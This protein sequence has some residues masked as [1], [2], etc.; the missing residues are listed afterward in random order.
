MYLKHDQSLDGAMASY[1]SN[2]DQKYT[3]E[4]WIM[5]VDNSVYDNTAYAENS[6]KLREKSSKYNMPNVQNNVVTKDNMAVAT[7]PKVQTYKASGV[8]GGYYIIANVFASAKNANNFVKLLNSQ[9][10]NASYFIN[11]E[12]NYRYVYLKKHDSW[13]NALVSYYSKINNAYQQKM[14]VMKVSQNLIA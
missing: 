5:N 10:L 6:Q 2:V 9:G 7:T 13:S 12:N 4:K 14:W 3:G 1:S 11:P 8:D